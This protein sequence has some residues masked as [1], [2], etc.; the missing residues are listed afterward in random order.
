MYKSVQM[1]NAHKYALS[2]LEIG[3]KWFLF[4]FSDLGADLRRAGP[5]RFF[6]VT[7][8]LESANV[9]QT[10]KRQSHELHVRVFKGN[11][12]LFYSS[13]WNMISEFWSSETVCSHF[14]PYNKALSH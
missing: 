3:F 2:C 14:L 7:A 8:F 5:L 11:G 1:Y 13:G 9:P 12:D 10:T 6:A 4:L